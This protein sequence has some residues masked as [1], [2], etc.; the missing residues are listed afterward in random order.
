[1]AARVP[2]T[3][4]VDDSCPLV[5]VYRNQLVDLGKRPPTTRDGRPLLETIPNSF[6]D[7]FCDVVERHGIAGKLSIVPAPGGRGDVVRGVE[8][9]DPAMTQEW[10]R[11]AQ[12]RLGRRFDFTPEMLTHD[13]AL[14][15]STGTYLAES[16]SDWSQRQDRTTLTPYLIHSLELLKEVGVDAS[17][18]TSPWVFGERVEAEY[19]AAI[20]AA[21][22]AVCQRDLTWY[23]LHI[24]DRYPSARPHIAYARGATTVV[25]INSTVDDY[26]WQTIDSPRTDRAFVETVADQLLTA[27]GRA[28]GIR[29]VL[30][31]GGWPVLMTHWQG[32]FSN[33]LETGLAVLD[34]LGERVA[35]ALAGEVEWVSCLEMARRTVAGWRPA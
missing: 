2:M 29:T 9:F 24:W 20:A 16:E 5:H 18:V 26:F 4:L 6:L 28:G 10:L 17:G 22:Q 19:L 33:G 21:Q 14:D 3:L 25:S 23:Y 34:I 35:T 11:T 31:A 7:H 13:L 27:D 12:A 15:F 8:G 1:M 32:Y 30:D